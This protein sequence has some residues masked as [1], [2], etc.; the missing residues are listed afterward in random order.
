MPPLSSLAD[1]GTI[2]IIL[3]FVLLF[4]KRTRRSGITVGV[5]LIMSLLCANIILKPLVARIRPY[6]VNTDVVLLIK[7]FTDYSFPS[8]HTLASF[9]AAGSLMFTNRRLGYPALVLASLIAL[10]RLYLY[11]HYPSDV[12]TSVLLGLLFAYLSYRL[13]RA[14]CERFDSMRAELNS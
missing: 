12:I 11:V 9:C 4:F 5:S 2:W 13:V 10:S 7:R 8:G 14:I 1:A 6:D 3:A